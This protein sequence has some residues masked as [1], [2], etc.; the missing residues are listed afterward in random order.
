MLTSHRFFGGFSGLI[1]LIG[2]VFPVSA[3]AGMEIFICGGSNHTCSSNQPQ[4]YSGVSSD[5]NAA[6]T[7]TV[8]GA[9]SAYLD[10]PNASI[11]SVPLSGAGPQPLDHTQPVSPSNPLCSVN[12]S[13][14]SCDGGVS[15]SYTGG[16]TSPPT[17]ISVAPAG[18]S[19]VECSVDKSVLQADLNRGVAP[20]G[21]I[22]GNLNG[23]C[24]PASYGVFQGGTPCPGS[25]LTPGDAST[26]A[27]SV[28]AS[29]PSGMSATLD[30]TKPSGLAYSG[31]PSI[32]QNFFVPPP[33]SSV[34]IATDSAG[35]TTFNYSPSGV[36]GS[37]SGTMVSGTGTSQ[38]NLNT[39]SL[40]QDSSIQKLINDSAASTAARNTDIATAQSTLSGNSTFSSVLSIF[41]T[42]KSAV[43]SQ[44]SGHGFG[45][46]SLGFFPSNWTT[47]TCSPWTFTLYSYPVVIDLC[48]DI[49]VVD[50]ILSYLFYIATALYLFDLFYSKEA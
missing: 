1:F 49:A 50:S 35:N 36:T 15:S 18:S 2:S 20:G 3:F 12:G 29:V 40:A 4:P 14:L 44:S 34:V 7:G 42:Q 37:T 22:V 16:G 31:T 45:G 38:I 17:P 28:S 11:G 41:D 5:Y 23:V 39:A 46:P 24:G 32:I 8:I 6:G 21:Y 48:P 43:T 26:C 25:S 13:S 30:P 33:G 10:V 27:G 47:G 19:Y 9:G